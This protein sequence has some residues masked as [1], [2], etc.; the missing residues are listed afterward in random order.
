[1][2]EHKE[3]IKEFKEHLETLGYN[4]SSVYGLPRCA[5]EFLSMN[6]HTDFSA[7]TATHIKTFHEFLQQRPN[8]KS[9]GGLSE[10]TIAHYLYSLKMFF[11]YLEITEQIRENPMSMLTFKSPQSNA[12]EILTQQEIGQ[13]FAA[14]AFLRE[15]AILHLFY[16]CGLRR[17][18]AAQ[19]NI[20][21]IHFRENM[22]F[23]REG[24][25][26][27]RRVVPMTKKVKD[28]LWNYFIEER[29]IYISRKS[30]ADAFLLN[31]W[32]TRLQGYGYSSIVKN[33]VHRAKII[34]QN[35]SPHSLRHSIA[36]HLLEN[37]VRI[38]YVRN[39][40]GHEFLATTQIYTRVS[41]KQL[42]EINAKA[43]QT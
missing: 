27:K 43:H 34:F 5:E 39:F 18:E 17:N 30:P 36:T 2:K 13:L 1:M 7:I 11:N 37:G 4:K 28:D 29:N 31:K 25:G 23:V 40:L 8:K 21:D 10:C 20:R 19:L 6:P 15:T 16:S 42:L 33:L 3:K 32:G 41:K 35:I 14:C 38:E 26:Y 12:R 9:S 24:K 22:L